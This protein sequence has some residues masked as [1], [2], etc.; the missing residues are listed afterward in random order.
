[1]V[2][3][4]SR[5][6]GISRKNPS[7]ST[8]ELHK[9]DGSIATTAHWPP[10]VLCG[11]AV[12]GG[13]ASASARVIDRK[14][15]KMFIH[16][17]CDICSVAQHTHIYIIIVHACMYVSVWVGT[18]VSLG[19]RAY[20]HTHMHICTYAHIHSQQHS[21][22]LV[23]TVD[24]VVP[25]WMTKHAL[26]APVCRLARR[27]MST[28]LSFMQMACSPACTQVCA[29]EWLACNGTTAHIVHGRV[30]TGCDDVGRRPY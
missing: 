25:L 2:T 4:H 14:S 11:G 30:A 9:S 17:S 16:S 29:A 21:H 7:N 22:M 6:I 28:G 26:R 1:M 10:P 20:R 5:P 19:S 18:Q 13:G 24:M 12:S 27:S 15:A 23:A 3:E 8:P